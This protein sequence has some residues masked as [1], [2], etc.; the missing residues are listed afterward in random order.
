MESH[1]LD[2]HGLRHHEV[3]IRIENFIFLNQGEFPLTIICGNSDKMIFLAIKVLKKHG[4]EFR[5]GTGYDYGKIVVY[6]L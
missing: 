4:C 1:T 6:K 3:D 5:E 2:L